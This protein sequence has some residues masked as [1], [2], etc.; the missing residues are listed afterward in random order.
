MQV[1][2]PAPVL[3]SYALIR[4]KNGVPRIDGNPSDLPEP[5]KQLLTSAEKAQLGLE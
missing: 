5:I 1:A 3:R 2:I 4:D